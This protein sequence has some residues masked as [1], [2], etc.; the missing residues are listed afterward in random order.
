MVSSVSSPEL[1]PPVNNVSQRGEVDHDDSTVLSH[2]KQHEDDHFHVGAPCLRNLT[3]R[4]HAD[5]LPPSWNLEGFLLLLAH[6]TPL[7]DRLLTPLFE[8]LSTTADVLQENIKSTSGDPPKP[9]S[10]S[11]AC[12]NDAAA[13]NPLSRRPMPYSFEGNAL[14][15]PPPLFGATP[16]VVGPTKPGGDPAHHHPSG[17]TPVGPGAATMGGKGAGTIVPPMGGGGGSG[18]RPGGKMGGAFGGGG[19][20]S[21]S[22]GG[23]GAAA[24]MGAGV[25]LPPGMG[26]AGPMGMGAGGGGMMVP[27]MVGGPGGMMPGMVGGPPGMPP[28]H[29]PGT[30]RWMEQVPTEVILECNGDVKVPLQPISSTGIH[31]LEWER[32]ARTGA[33]LSKVLAMLVKPV[34]ESARTSTLDGAGTAAMWSPRGNMLCTSM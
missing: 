20:S 19:P 4:S 11:S 33:F 27:G 23:P 2:N 16:S 22:M 6:L 12:A 21:A 13:N 25:V 24:M 14:Q 9:R 31:Y 17:T 28:P 5:F 7:Y 32:H 8:E 29:Q 10:S 26:I 1:P 18:A 34:P 15:R 3:V 30:S